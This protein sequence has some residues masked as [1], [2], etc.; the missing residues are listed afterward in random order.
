MEENNLVRAVTFII[1][2][3]RQSFQTLVTIRKIYTQK[4][5]KNTQLRVKIYIPQIKIN[6]F[7]LNE[8]TY[9]KLN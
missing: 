3:F 5:E 6:F 4:R 7:F 1:R 2:K 9:L 8:S